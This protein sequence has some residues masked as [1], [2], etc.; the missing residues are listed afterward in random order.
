MPAK[1]SE[2]GSDF[3]SGLVSALASGL[4]SVLAG[5]ALAF[6]AL[7]AS[8]AFLTM[9]GLP[10]AGLAPAALAAGLVFAGFVSAGLAS[11]AS[12]GL[13]ATVLCLKCFLAGLVSGCCGVEIIPGDCASAGAAPSSS[14]SITKNGPRRIV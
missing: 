6:F 5:S 8:I 12:A 9:P 10:V 2:A 13:A 1:T 3:A 14:A 11:A 4:A 7:R